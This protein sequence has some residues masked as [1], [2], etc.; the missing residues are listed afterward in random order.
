M[1]VALWVPAYTG[2][3]TGTAVFV[4]IAVLAPWLWPASPALTTSRVLSRPIAA[5]GSL[6]LAGGVIAMLFITA[7]DLLPS[8]FA[9][10]PDVSRADMLPLINS[11]VERVA[12]GRDPYSGSYQLANELRLPYGP[13]LWL[14]HLLAY[15]AH[16]DGRVFMLVGQLT[17]PVACGLAAVLS[18]RR[19]DYLRA[20]LFVLLAASLCREPEILTFHKNGHTQSYWPLLLVFALALHA[21]HWT[22][23][24]I[25]LAL[26]IGARTM[27]I[28]LVP[29][30][31]IALH[32][33]RALTWTRV[34][35][36]AGVLLLIFGVF[37]IDDARGLIDGMYFNY[38]KTTK[39]IVWNKTSWAISSYG[40]TGLLL[41][42]GWRGA[43]TPVQVAALAIVYL[44]SWRRLRAGDSPSPW[45]LVTLLVF[46]MTTFWPVLYIYFDVW[47]FGISALVAP[48][49]QMPSRPLRRVIGFPLLA[50]GAAG[51]VVVAAG[52]AAQPSHYTI[53]IGRV[54]ANGY[55]GGGFGTDV[56]VTDGDRTYEWVHDTAATIRVP[57]ASLFG[58]DIMLTMR[59]FAPT[60]TL[61]QAV[62]VTLN[63]QYLG[64]FDVPNEWTDLRV[65]AP[66]RAWIYGFNKLELRF[67]Y[68]VSEA[69]AGTGKETEAYSAAADRVVIE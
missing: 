37:L 12:Q 11:A 4:A 40:I 58:A 53:D 28:A 34:A 29:T 66:A 8:V 55:T 3:Q 30:F 2:F 10:P 63:G 65:P 25:V 67:R 46:D 33:R 50:A 54:E 21:E 26:L 22:A 64:H 14:P 17:V 61:H 19:R 15:W 23:A 1:I 42:R 44:W 27:M 38:V 45:M 48:V 57:R 60:Q 41:S 62:D 47:T 5:I 51:V 49:V 43:V 32:A 52:M 18:L 69:D 9:G 31:F 16:V 56:S 20:A 13:M 39:D 36:F 59:A 6:I 7:K 24:A 68:A 35:W